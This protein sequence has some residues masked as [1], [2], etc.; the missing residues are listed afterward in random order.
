MAIRRWLV[1]PDTYIETQEGPLAVVSRGLHD[2]AFLDGSAMAANAGGIFTARPERHPTG[3]P[4]EMVTTWI[5]CEWKDRVDA[6][7]QPEPEGVPL[8]AAGEQTPQLTAE[9]WAV[10]QQIQE[11]ADGATAE[12]VMGAAS[13]GLEVV[14]GGSAS[15]DGLDYSQ[16]EDEDL[17]EIPEGAR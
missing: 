10:A 8:P 3:F 16:L 13:E 4:G 1:R 2:Q 17:A 5:A 6:K 7:E 9:Q 12:D 11:A 15:S 14:K